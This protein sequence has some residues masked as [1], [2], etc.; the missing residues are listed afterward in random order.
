MRASVTNQVGVVAPRRGRG[1]GTNRGVPYRAAYMVEISATFASLV[2][3]LRKWLS[4][5]YF[6][7]MCEKV[8]H[9]ARHHTRGR[10]P[11]LTLFG[12]VLAVSLCACL[13]HATTTASASVAASARWV[14]TSC[15]LTR[16]R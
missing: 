4:D 6:R 9:S 10:R 13:C 12:R 14:A 16:T 2:P 1:Q 7:T 8:G 5:Q 11:T 15:G 3:K